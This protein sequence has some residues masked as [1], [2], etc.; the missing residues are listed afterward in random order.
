MIQPTPPGLA[1]EQQRKAADRHRARLVLADQAARANATP[2][3]LRAL[4]D[5]CGLLTDEEP[6]PGSVLAHPFETNRKRWPREDG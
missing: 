4:L 3:E 1:A 2:A 6:D 5:M